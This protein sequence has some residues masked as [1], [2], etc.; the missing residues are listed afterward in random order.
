RRGSGAMTS[1]QGVEPIRMRK[2][3]RVALAAII[4]AA[5]Q[6][7]GGAADACG[8]A[9]RAPPPNVVRGTEQQIFEAWLASD[10]AAVG[11][12]RGVDSTLGPRYHVA[13]IERVWSGGAAKGRLVFKAPRGVRAQRGDRTI[14][15]LWDRLAA[16]TDSY[17][18][19]SKSRYGDNIW[20]T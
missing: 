3:L 14:F 19:E 13:D 4:A 11:N 10:V 18:E 15:F 8:A 7:P 17:L 6:A 16:A 12:Y 1:P 2:A 9:H 20:A 5:S